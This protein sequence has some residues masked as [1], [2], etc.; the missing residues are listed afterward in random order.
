MAV[1]SDGRFF[2]PPVSVWWGFAVFLL[3]A[4]GQDWT[5]GQTH[6]RYY[7]ELGQAETCAAVNSGLA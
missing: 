3:L 7:V 6:A 2:W 4:H 1:A 5:D